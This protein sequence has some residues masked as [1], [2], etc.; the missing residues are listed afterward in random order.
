MQELAGKCYLSDCFG[1][2]YRNLYRDVSRIAN[3]LKYIC[4][5]EGQ[6]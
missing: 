2:S 1:L 5:E 4:D 6:F 3:V